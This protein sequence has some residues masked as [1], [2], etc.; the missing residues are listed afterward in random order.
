MPFLQA[1]Y[2]LA[3]WSARAAIAARHE[4][5]TRS[6]WEF[7]R[8]DPAVPLPIRAE[9][10]QWGLPLDEFQESANFPP[11]LYVREAARMRG[12]VV[13]TQHNVFGAATARSNAS[14]GLSRWLIDIHNVINMAVPPA[15]TG[16]GWEVAATGL[17]NT[18]HGVW[19]LTE[20]PYGAL[21]PR[22]GQASNLLVPVCASFTH[23]AF[24][25]Y[26]LEPQY[27][28]FGHSAGVAAVMAAR[29]GAAVQDVGIAGLQAELRAQGQLLDATP[30][31][32]VG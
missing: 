27:A 21:T 29:A 14:V 25:A 13:L 8:T 4:W 30:P 9:A 31:Q 10:A 6:A 3:N 1:A 22:S 23:V 7:L 17:A 15:F 24:S 11:Q 28:V 12:A 16:R 20:V 26:R 19:Q 5:F 18:A 2:P 32:T